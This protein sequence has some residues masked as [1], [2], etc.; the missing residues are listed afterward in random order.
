MAQQ[1]RIKVLQ[2]LQTQHTLSSPFTGL[3]RINFG[4]RI[5]RC[6]KLFFFLEYHAS[7]MSLQTVRCHWNG[8]PEQS[9]LSL[10]QISALETA[11]RSYWSGQKTSSIWGPNSVPEKVWKKLAKRHS[12]VIYWWAFYQF[13]LTGKL[14]REHDTTGRTLKLKKKK[15]SILH[16]YQ[17]HSLD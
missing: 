14:K 9:H 4:M 16:P 3:F 10:W 7:T 15:D 5:Y 8:R 13:I 12:K 6:C 17:H 1:L 11:K 2:T